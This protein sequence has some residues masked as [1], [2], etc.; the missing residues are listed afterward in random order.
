MVPGS[1]TELQC[2]ASYQRVNEQHRLDLMDKNVGVLLRIWEMGES[3]EWEEH[4][5]GILE[6]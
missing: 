1:F 6:N 4:M 3:G 5:G 2:L